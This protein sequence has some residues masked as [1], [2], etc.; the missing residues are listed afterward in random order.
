MLEENIDHQPGSWRVY[1]KQEGASSQR[2]YQRKF[3]AGAYGLADDLPQS[4]TDTT[5]LDAFL[6]LALPGNATE[7]NTL[8]EQEHVLTGDP[9]VDRVAQM[10]T[11][12][13]QNIIDGTPVEDVMG[14]LRDQHCRGHHLR[15][16]RSRH[17]RRVKRGNEPLEKPGRSH[18]LDGGPRPT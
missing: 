6:M 3:G 7:L 10:L 5:A 15:D 16:S 1:D 13:L 2:S 12:S 18:I 14:Q 8:L 17:R 11:F 4:T 9:V